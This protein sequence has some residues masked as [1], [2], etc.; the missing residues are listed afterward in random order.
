M[1]ERISDIEDR[2]LEIKQKEEE[3]NQ[4]IKNNKRETQELA[5]I[6]RRGNVRIT[7]IIESEE[8]DQGLESIFRQ[9]VDE[10]FSNLSKELELGI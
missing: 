2:N 6:I 10:N 9:I 5:D 4:R 1:E 3:R 8:K 7:G